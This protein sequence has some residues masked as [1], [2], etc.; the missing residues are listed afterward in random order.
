MDI[1]G[2]KREAAKVVS[3]LLNFE[4]KRRLMD[5]TQEILA[6]FSDDLDLL[7]MRL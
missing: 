5:I 1:L 4:K 2:M 7:G 6:T 3:K